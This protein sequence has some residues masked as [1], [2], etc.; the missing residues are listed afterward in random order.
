MKYENTNTMAKLLRELREN[1]NLTQEFIA[2]KLS[3]TRSAYAYYEHGKTEPNINSLRILAKIYNVNP[4]YFL[5][6]EDNSVY[7]NDS[8][9]ARSLSA[10]SLKTPS[11]MTSLTEEER[12]LIV[13][14]RLANVRDKRKSFNLLDKPTKDK[15]K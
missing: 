6:A 14:Y 7:V 2:S 9:N 1:N 12:Q 3:I 10:N 11:S 15:N 5:M 8:G 4:E 13:L